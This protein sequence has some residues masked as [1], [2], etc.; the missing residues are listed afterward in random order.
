MKRERDYNYYETK[1]EHLTLWRPI[2]LSRDQ[3]CCRACQRTE[4]LQLAH[5]SPCLSFVKIYGVQGIE[6]SFRDDNLI[7]LCDACHKAH[8][9]FLNGEHLDS[10]TRSRAIIVG[11]IFNTAVKTRGWGHPGNLHLTV[12]KETKKPDDLAGYAIKKRTLEK[13]DAERKKKIRR[14]TRKNRKK[15]RVGTKR[16]DATERLKK[17]VAT[18][19]VLCEQ[20]KKPELRIYG[21]AK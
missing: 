2:I 5:I 13:L 15:K 7:T 16:E 18:A 8:H 9:R 6:F 1:Q 10:R 12:L 14:F 21:E 19:Q 4:K 3:F 11:K 20:R 17:I